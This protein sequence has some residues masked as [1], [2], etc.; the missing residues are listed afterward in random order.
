LEK[1][2]RVCAARLVVT[3]FRTGDSLVAMYSSR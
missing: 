3:R 2:A 1:I